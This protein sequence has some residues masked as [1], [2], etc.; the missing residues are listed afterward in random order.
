[1]RGSKERSASA[2]VAAGARLGSGLVRLAADE[3]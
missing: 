1:V 3:S 2:R